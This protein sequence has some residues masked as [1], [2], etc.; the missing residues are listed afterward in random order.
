LNA[1]KGAPAVARQSQKNKP[2]PSL[3]V[4]S[5]I[6]ALFRARNGLFRK[7]GACWTTPSPAAKSLAVGQR[8]FVE[9]MEDD[10]EGEP[11]IGRRRSLATRFTFYETR[12]PLMGAISALK[13]SF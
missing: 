9:R 10:L 2:L 6:I 5:G 4:K 13:L 1:K 3:G 12:V 7:V 11:G 8:E